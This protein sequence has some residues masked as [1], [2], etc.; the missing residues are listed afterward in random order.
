MELLGYV[1]EEWV[2]LKELIWWWDQISIDRWWLQVKW[3]VHCRE[4]IG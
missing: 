4:C 3:E 1:G 2:N